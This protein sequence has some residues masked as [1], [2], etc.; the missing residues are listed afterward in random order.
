MGLGPFLVGFENPR[1]SSWHLERRRVIGEIQM[2]HI[3]TAILGLDPLRRRPIIRQS[4]PHTLHLGCE[5]KSQRERTHR[6]DLKESRDA[7]TLGWTARREENFPH[8]EYGV[9][10]RDHGVIGPDFDR[11][12]LFIHIDRYGIIL[13]IGTY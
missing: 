4:R 12:R 3:K 8:R 9:G 1:T 11:S 6:L 5:G 7:R 13:D 2:Q 10:K